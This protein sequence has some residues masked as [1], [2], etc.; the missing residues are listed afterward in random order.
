VRHTA[1]NSSASQSHGSRIAA[2]LC[3]AS[4]W[5]RRPSRGGLIFV[6]KAGLSH[7]VRAAVG[8]LS[9]I[10]GIEGK[11]SSPVRRNVAVAC[12]TTSVGWIA[13][14]SSACRSG[15]IALIAGLICMRLAQIAGI[16]L[17]VAAY[18][19]TDA[20]LEPQPCPPARRSGGELR[21]RDR[22]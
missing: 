6:A 21:I 15:L 12:S 4:A 10:S 22:R 9:W 19:L 13:G 17:L 20:E 16:A 8:V 2:G 14:Q 18:E 11:P 1:G 5:T 3:V 7:A